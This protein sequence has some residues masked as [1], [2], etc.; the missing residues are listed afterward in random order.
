MFDTLSGGEKQ[1]VVIASALAQFESHGRNHRSRTPG[2]RCCCST[3]R[4]HRSTSRYQL[5]IASLLRRLNRERG[6]T[7]VVSTHDLNFAAASARRVVLLQKGRVLAARPDRRDVLTRPTT[8]A[9]LY[10]VD[11]DVRSARPR[12]PPD[13][14]ARSAGRRT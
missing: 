1:R 4:R 2:R 11:A 13:G 3:S 5:E 8:L 9:A 10:G 6:L 14:R 12:R 7:I